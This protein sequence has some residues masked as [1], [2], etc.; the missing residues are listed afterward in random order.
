MNSAIANNVWDAQT[1]AQTQD[2]WQPEN[3]LKTKVLAR[4]VISLIMRTAQHRQSWMVCQ[5][6]ISN[7]DIGIGHVC[8]ST[9]AYRTSVLNP[10]S[11]VL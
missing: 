8:M 10:K 5:H 11:V 6:H 4:E 2:S 3:I 7:T 9:A 1:D